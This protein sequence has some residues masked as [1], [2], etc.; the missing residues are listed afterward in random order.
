[1][2]LTPSLA[3]DLGKIFSY[4]FQNLDKLEQCKG[5]ELNR[6]CH[7]PEMK[8]FFTDGNITFKDVNISDKTSKDNKT[9]QTHFFV[10]YDF[11]DMK[12]SKEEILALPSEIMHN[13]IISKMPNQ[14]IQNQSELIIRSKDKSQFLI[15]VDCSFKHKARKS[16]DVVQL[17][18]KFLNFNNPND[19][20][21]LFKKLVS[22]VNI[23]DLQILLDSKTL[24]QIIF[25]RTKKNIENFDHKT[26]AATTMLA[27]NLVQ[28]SIQSKYNLSPDLVDKTKK[29]FS[30]ITKLLLGEKQKV[31]IKMRFKNDSYIALSTIEKMIESSDLA[32]LL[33]LFE[34]EFI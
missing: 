27:L 31:G 4:L 33:E 24:H 2:S 14:I 13:Q 9:S 34:I 12:I 19:L 21:A 10:T 18:T 30:N 26:Y 1:M 3:Q 23:K 6:Q 11:K 7:I 16:Y 29:L 32:G 20:K 17:Y 8:L 28:G 22:Q 5:D 15:K 25:N